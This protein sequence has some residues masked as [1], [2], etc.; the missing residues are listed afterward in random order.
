[1]TEAT[2]RRVRTALA[3]FPRSGNTWLRYMIELATGAASGSVY[4]D[5]ILPRGREGIVIKTHLLNR[6]EFDRAIHLVRNP[7]DAIESYYHWK[8]DVQGDAATGWRQHVREAAAEWRAHTSHWLAGDADRSGD[9]DETGQSAILLVRYEDLRANPVRELERV[10]NYLGC[11]VSKEACERA[12][13]LAE[14]ERM[15]ELHP[16]LGTRFFRK[17]EVGAGA[18]AFD[19]ESRTVVLQIIGDLINRLG[20][21]RSPRPFL[22]NSVPKSGTHLVSK[23]LSLT[24]GIDGEFQRL[25]PADFAAAAGEETVDIGIGLPRTASMMR[26]RESLA[27]LAPGQ[28]ALWH[29]PYSERMRHLLHELNLRMVLIVRDPRDVVVSHVQHLL[30]FKQHRLHAR[31]ARLSPAAQQRVI[32][33]GWI[34]EAAGETLL[35][36][37]RER[38]ETLLRWRGQLP[39]LLVRFEDLV[40][41]VGGASATA[42]RAA[43]RALLDFVGASAGADGIDAIAANLFGD[44]VT[45]RRGQ[46]GSWRGELC[47]E[48]IALAEES[49]GEIMR[50]LGYELSTV[51]LQPRGR[52]GVTPFIIN[53]FP[54]SGTKLLTKLC[55]MIQ[56]VSAMPF[57]ER[58]RAL[59]MLGEGWSSAPVHG[60]AGARPSSPTTPAE[61][62]AILASIPRGQFLE[63][64]L[65]YSREL[66]H[67]LNE[68][69]VPM[70]MMVRDPRD[71]TI[72]LANYLATTVD[73]PLHGFFA[74]MS[75]EERVACAITGVSNIGTYGPELGS[76][77]AR[78]RRRLGWLRESNAFVVRFEDLVGPDGGGDAACQMQAINGILLHIGIMPTDE[79]VARL[80]RDSFGGTATFHRGRIGH[81][82]EIFTLEHQ[83][84]WQKHAGDIV[85]A[86]GYANGGIGPV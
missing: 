20:Y 66:A 71:A 28:F 64:H 84:L 72:S 24:P 29:V 75:P 48:S 32:I 5:R 10:L 16:T 40:G 33:E 51:N 61:A 55:S 50:E 17:G 62:T 83:A 37:L 53:S 35:Q 27:G 23:A 38:C 77:A 11:N 44:T 81:W 1:M 47:S 42:Q 58:W 59:S 68:R 3:S 70:L 63:Y 78:Y 9:E 15:R 65:A 18:A 19:D 26:V 8:R 76:V 41:E 86:L 34:D 39:T 13:Q 74:S 22:V 49:C 4:D 45:F 73:H 25:S 7:F 69:R 85:A 82:R 36:P 14:L 60:A 52:A 46:V 31:F 67:L 56:G 2:Q 21:E 80:A 57:D 12:V 30:R 6:H 54:K 43:L 79:L